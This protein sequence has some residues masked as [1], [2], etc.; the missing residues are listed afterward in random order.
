MPRTKGVKNGTAGTSDLYSASLSVLVVSADCAASISF[1]HILQFW[2]AFVRQNLCNSLVVL[3]LF[4]YGVHNWWKTEL[5]GAGR[6]D[7]GLLSRQSSN[8][9]SC[10]INVVIQRCIY[11][12]LPLRNLWQWGGDVVRNCHP[13]SQR[14]AC[15]NLSITFINILFLNYCIRE[16]AI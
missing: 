9:E 4:F 15:L 8:V 1:D 10:F 14:N 2:C 13:T 5:V 7:W 11:S 12:P 16:G 6:W 3:V